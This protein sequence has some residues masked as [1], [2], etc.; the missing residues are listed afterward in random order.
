M[1]VDAQGGVCQD[2]F[3]RV[4]GHLPTGVT[5]V[6]ATSA[7]ERHGMTANTVTSVSLDPVML[8]VCLV[9]G[10]RTARA[11]RES[12]AFSVNV[13]RHDQ[14]AISHRFACRG[15]DHFEGLDVVDGPRDLPRLPG[16]LAFVCCRVE[17]VMAAGDHDI[18]LGEVEHCEAAG[19]D[20]LVF[21]QGAYLRVS[22]DAAAGGS[23][24]SG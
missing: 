1:S 14:E 6:A 9:R 5:I 4:M 21:F 13:L 19:G 3:R 11:V 24:W 15:V 22:C 8:L 10:S 18:V 20:A 23:T 7:G 16:C 12:R 17:D 2:A